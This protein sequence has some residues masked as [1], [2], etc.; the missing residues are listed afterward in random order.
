[1]SITTNTSKKS[2]LNGR[3]LWFVLAVAAA[4]AAAAIIF[5]IMSIATAKESY[6]VLNQDVPAR[7]PITVDLL[8]EVTTS[9]GTTPPSALSFGEISNEETYSLYSLKS[10]DVLTSSNTGP[11]L[12]LTEGLPSDFVVASFTANPSMA[13]GGNVQ[14]GDYIDIIALINDTEVTGTASTGASYVLQ[15]VL[16]IDA[17]VDLDTYS[18]DGAESTTAETP[19]TTDGEEGTVSSNTNDS[20]MRSGIPT[21]FTV[22]LSPENAAVL[23]LATQH[24]LYIVLSSAESTADGI[25]PTNLPTIDSKSLWGQA[26][27]AGEG[28]DNTFGQGGEVVKPT[29]PTAPTPEETEVPSTPKNTEEPSTPEDTTDPGNGEQNQEETQE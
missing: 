5:S 2:L 24:D 9:A 6:W 18:S 12:P 23:A 26:R 16:V 17:T 3:K 10:G 15:R 13:A 4:I 7:T 19:T 22:G 21:M 28:T 11:L 1:M 14:R 25:V 8:T 27:N 20:A 29:T